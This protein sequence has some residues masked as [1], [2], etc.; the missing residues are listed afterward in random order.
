MAN[1]KIKIAVNARMLLP[2]KTEGINRVA[3]EIL[4]RICVN[5]PDVH[6]YFLFDRNFSQEFIFA[7]NITP[8]ILSPQ[9]RHP[10]LWYIWFEYSVSSILKKLKPNLFFSPD[11]WIP[12]KVNIKKVNI[13]HDINFVHYPKDFPFFYRK[14][15]NYFFP[16]FAKKSEKIITVSK[17]SKNE[18]IKYFNIEP[19]KI[20]VVY[21]GVSNNFTPLNDKEKEIVRKNFS[22]SLPY[23]LFVG[24]LLPRKNISNMLLAYDIFRSK[25]DSVF[26]LLIAGKKKWWTKTMQKTYNNL[27]FKK[28]VRLLSYVDEKL[29]TRLF[30]SSFALLYVPVYEGFGLPVVEAFASGVPVIS[31]NTSSIP[32][33]SNNAALLANPNSPTDIAEKM[34]ELYYNKSLYK[35]LIKQGLIQKNKFNWDKSAQKVWKILSQFI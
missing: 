32:E 23:F 1:K 12:L 22:G 21:N 25:T 5:N 11:G 31:S 35:K 27:R 2:S 7:K 34:I 3:Y 33:I 17:F 14:Y 20:T 26:P 29:L 19:K 6:F 30:A 13:I 28:D 4:N 18:I 24:T 9:A 16:L 8:I 10:L 15:L